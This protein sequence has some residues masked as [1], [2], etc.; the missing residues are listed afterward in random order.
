[1]RSAVPWW[2]WFVWVVT[3]VLCLVAYPHLP[4]V[5]ATHFNAAGQPNGFSRRSVAAF[6][7]PGIALVMAM[8]WSV[9]WRIDPK[10]VNYPSFW[11]TY[12]TIG[13]IIIVFLCATQAWLL[14]HSLGVL[15]LSFRIILTL[16]GLLFVILSNLLPRIQPNWWLGVRT[17]WTLSSEVSWRKTHRLAGHLGVVAGLLIAILAWVLPTGIMAISMTVLI[18]VWAGIAVVASYVYARN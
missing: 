4:A 1:M 14:G 3:L 7:A 12:S 6:L 13:G 10:R 11:S 15:G 18:M 5:V 16:L 9:L 8:L 17:P 2:A